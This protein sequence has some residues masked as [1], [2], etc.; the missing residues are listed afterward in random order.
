MQ[1]RPFQIQD[2]QIVISLWEKCGLIRTWND[3]RKDI[4]RK[5]Q[6]NPELFLVGILNDQV[7]A[8]IMAGYDG[9]RGWLNYLAV[10][11][12]YQRNGYANMLVTKAEQLLLEMGC[13]KINLQ[14]RTTNQTIKDYYHQIG[15]QV[16]DCI[17]MGKRLIPDN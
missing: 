14:I 8:T 1:I 15:Y 12:D 2:E 3:P 11:F 4:Q 13:P 9:H 10:D 16:D 5:L 17:S 6:V 7:I